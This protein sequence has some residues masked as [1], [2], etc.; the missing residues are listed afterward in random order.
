[1]LR[2]LAGLVRPTTNHGTRRGDFVL[3]G[4]NIGRKVEAPA[5]VSIKRWRRRE[6]PLNGKACR[7]A[8]ATSDGKG[9]QVAG[10]LAANNN[11]KILEFLGQTA[12][13]TG[14]VSDMQRH[15]GDFADSA[16]VAGNNVRRS[17]LNFQ[18]EP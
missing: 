15:D 3:T 12:T 11:A 8:I 10:G 7:Q 6:H 5:A 13:V 4:K 1:V 9:Y 16:K 18:G 2:K 17:M 14:D